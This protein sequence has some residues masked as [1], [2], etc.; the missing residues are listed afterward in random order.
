MAKLQKVKRAWI[1][2]WVRE[3]FGSQLD[4]AEHGEVAS[5]LPANYSSERVC[6]LLQRLYAER[7]Y[8]A[9]E[10][11]SKRSK[12]LEEPFNPRK[13][14]GIAHSGVEYIMGYYS[15]TNP[16]LVA[17]AAENIVATDEHNLTWQEI[18]PPHKDWM[19]DHAG[20]KDCP[21]LNRGPIIKDVQGFKKS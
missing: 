14:H 7:M 12:H 17:K 10:T 16:M 2:Y 15:S 11:L 21:D 1:L 5:I 20:V 18:I 19:C 4:I 6:F 8:T 13:I 3:D 9:A